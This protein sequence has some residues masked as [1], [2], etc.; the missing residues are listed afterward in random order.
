ML[1]VFKLQVAMR[2]QLLTFGD[3]H[4]FVTIAMHTFPSSAIQKKKIRLSQREYKHNQTFAE[5]HE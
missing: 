1:K 5:N 4:D 2:V 3:C